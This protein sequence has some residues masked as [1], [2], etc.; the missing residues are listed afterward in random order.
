MKTGNSYD[1]RVEPQEVDFTLRCKAAA[2]CNNILNI[3]GTDAQ[4]NGF[5][6][7]TLMR[8][9]CSW[10]LSRFAVEFDSLP[11]QFSTFS[12]RTWVNYDGRLLSTRNFELTDAEGNVFGRS[13]S[14]WAM[15][16]FE[17]RRPTDLNEL[18]E[19]YTSILS[20]EEPP[21][22]R[23]RKL[24]PI[25][26]SQTME[27]RIVYSD[28]DFN[29]HVNTLRYIDMMTDML[30]I[31]FF[32]HPRPV[33]LDFHFVKEARYGQSL[34]VGM[35]LQENSVLFEIK[36]DDGAAVCRASFQWR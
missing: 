3:A 12:I 8:N 14:Q 21:C 24:F 7:D 28:I 30:P 10:V 9:N 29:R 25:E 5:G 27:H 13:V 20:D 26:P 4:R 19:C 23:P 31:E 35:A 16:N 22:E 32:A 6:V 1:M 18:A 34:A 36:S 11:M 33:R 17:T 2:M 15:I